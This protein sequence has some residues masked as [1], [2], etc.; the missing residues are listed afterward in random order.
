MKKIFSDKNL[1]SLLILNFL[2][3][4]TEAAMYLRSTFLKA[5]GA[6]AEETGI[7]FAV[8]GII[9]VAAP[10]IGGLLADKVFKRYQVFLITAALYGLFIFLTPVS[11]Q[12][13]IGMMVCSF[14]VI[15]MYEVFHPVA[16]G[17]VDTA[18]INASNAVKGSD[19]SLI[20]LWMSLGF[21]LFNVLMTPLINT[22]SITSCYIVLGMLCVVSCFFTGIV[23]RNSGQEAVPDRSNEK[24]ANKNLRADIKKLF[25]NYYLISFLLLCVIVTVAQVNTGYLNY[26]LVENDLPVSSIGLISGLKVTGEIII[27]LLFPVLRKKISLSGFQ[28]LSGFLFMLQLLLQQF[29]KT[30]PEIIL[31]EMIGGLANGMII[32]SVAHYLRALAPVG[33]EATAI[34]LRVAA[35]NLG[36][37]ILSIVEGNII[38]RFGILTCYRFSMDLE[39]VFVVLFVFTLLFGKYVLKQENVCPILIMPKKGQI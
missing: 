4:G 2:F 31:F 29:A 9:G 1:R 8:S 30:V 34:L 39:L 12:L 17:L 13:K 3:G 33:L 23:K 21:L 37:G 15:P 35:K 5:N 14:L 6:T 20:R 24:F 27:M 18:S 11:G 22:L 16:L 10:I 28:I 32:S 25:K 19:Y 7:I 36:N 26:L 38:D